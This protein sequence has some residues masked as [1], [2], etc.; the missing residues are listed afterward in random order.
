MLNIN[1][2]QFKRSFDTYS[3]VQNDVQPNN[4]RGEYKNCDLIGSLEEHTIQYVV[5]AETWNGT[6]QDVYVTVP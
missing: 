4:D 2:Y 6:Y 5:Q 3:V 1:R